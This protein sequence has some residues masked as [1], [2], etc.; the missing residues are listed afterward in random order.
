MRIEEE[1]NL[2]ARGEYL[3]TIEEATEK[4]SEE[5]IEEGSEEVIEVG[6]EEEIEVV[7][8]EMIEEE[9]E[10]VSEEVIEEEIVEGSEEVI[11]EGSEEEI[12]MVS[13]EEIEEVSEE[14]IEEDQEEVSE[15]V[16]ATTTTLH[17]C[18]EEIT[19]TI[20]TMSRPTQLKSRDGEELLQTTLQKQQQQTIGGMPQLQLRQEI[21]E[22]AKLPRQT[23]KSLQ[24]RLLQI[25]MTLGDQVERPMELMPLPQQQIGVRGF[26][27]VALPL[28]QIT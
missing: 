9:I 7:T 25:T 8:E 22:R 17:L 13:E 14:E 6:S 10:A 1:G 15:E 3:E 20:K 26:L 28:K 12:E 16:I 24:L 11:E 19:P 2:E 23:P 18:L 5:V 21:G 27:I 4:G